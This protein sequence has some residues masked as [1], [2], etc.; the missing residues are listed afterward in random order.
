MDM[1]ENYPVDKA[2]VSFVERAES[3]TVAT[4]RGADQRGFL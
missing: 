2:P 3:H 4:L 1:S